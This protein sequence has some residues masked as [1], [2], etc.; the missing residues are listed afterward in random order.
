MLLELLLTGIHTRTTVFILIYY[1]VLEPLTK[2]Y[3]FAA[4][5]VIRERIDFNFDISAKHGF[6][7]GY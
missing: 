4:K 2:W 6:H 1:R 5:V 7:F 3:L